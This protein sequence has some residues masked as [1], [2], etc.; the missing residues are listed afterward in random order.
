MVSQT[1]QLERETEEARAR[2]EQTLQELRF[3]V[4][5]GQLLDQATDY[6][7]NSNGRAFASNLRDQVVANPLPV[8]LVGAGLAL[9][10]LSAKAK[11]RV[12]PDGTSRRRN[13]LR[14][15]RTKTRPKK[16]ASE[17]NDGLPTKVEDWMDE[18]SSSGSRAGTNI[19]ETVDEYKDSAVELY[20]DTAQG[21]RR[22]ANSAREYGRTLRQAVGSDGILMDFCRHQPVLVAGI[23]LAIGAALGSLLP[24]TS[25][26]QRVMGRAS[27]DVKDQ[28]EETA[29]EAL[30][31]LREAPRSQAG[32]TQ[33]AF[34]PD[35]GPNGSPSEKRAETSDTPSSSTA[36]RMP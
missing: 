16:E 12:G 4:S 26:E 24:T 31:S 9:L 22:A 5:P 17:D 15:D 14:E 13:G 2:V 32:E 6:L 23:G 11:G 25:T 19:R 10:A 28:L 34:G 29:D 36:Q 27:R 1:A 20:Q 3:R 33:D 7:R 30:N 18:P 8:T 21:A 35:V